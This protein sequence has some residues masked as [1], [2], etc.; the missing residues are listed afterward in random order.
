MFAFGPKRS[1]GHTCKLYFKSFWRDNSNVLAFMKQIIML[2]SFQRRKRL[3][4]SHDERG[5]PAPAIDLRGDPGQVSRLLLE[6][7]R[8][9]LHDYFEEILRHQKSVR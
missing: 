3:Q 7:V 5:P 1:H 9:G 6:G 4:M 2:V 8:R